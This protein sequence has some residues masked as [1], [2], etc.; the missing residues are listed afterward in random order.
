MN[1]IFDFDGTICNSFP[2]VVEIINKHFPELNNPPISADKAREIGTKDII[3]GSK[4]TKY[5]VIRLL[6]IG[7]REMAKHISEL[8]TFPY[9]KRV[10]KKTY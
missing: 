6:V 10:L 9:I 2:A 7:R 1:L 8:K 3:K 5:K 4:L